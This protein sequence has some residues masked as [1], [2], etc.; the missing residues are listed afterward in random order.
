LVEDFKA[1]AEIIFE[2]SDRHPRHGKAGVTGKG[3][4]RVDNFEV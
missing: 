4:G 3:G 2:G 1:P